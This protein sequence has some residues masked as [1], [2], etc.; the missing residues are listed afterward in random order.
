VSLPRA[1]LD[2]D[3]IYSRVLHELIGRLATGARFFDLIWSEEL[4]A[5]AESSLIEGKGLSAEAAAAW[6]GHVRREFPEGR[7]DLAA[8]PADL[9]LA[10]LTEDPD[11]R[12]VCALA[13]AGDADL[14]FSFDRGYLKE[15]LRRH[16]VEVPDLDT[17]LVERCE[18][19]PL[20]CSRVVEAQADAWGGGRPLE[21]LL[22]AF[23]RANVPRFAAALRGALDL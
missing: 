16:G 13:I 18:E 2:A 22:A 7:V 19:E 1:V 9:D 11:D 17:F 15:P 3:V 5:E 12:H 8:L 4:L 14:L 10:A 20:A 21:E 6:V 23:G